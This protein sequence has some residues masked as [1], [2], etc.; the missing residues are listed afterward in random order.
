[1][2]VTHIEELGGN[3]PA[4]EEEL[5]VYEGRQ[6]SS[7]AFVLLGVLILAGIYFAF[8]RASS[9][10]VKIGVFTFLFLI[11]RLLMAEYQKKPVPQ[12]TINREGIRFHHKD[13]YPWHT[14]S[15]VVYEEDDTAGKPGLLVLRFYQGGVTSFA[16][17]PQLDRPLEAI[18]AYINKYKMDMGWER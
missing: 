12:L 6:K 7:V 8:G 3:F 10:Y 13:V 18:A 11:I 15:E 1:M 14:I 4:D 2:R 9:M 5:N 17:T 16:I